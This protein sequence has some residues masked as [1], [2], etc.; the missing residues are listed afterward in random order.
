MQV[1]GSFNSFCY[2]F[3]VVCWPM[4]VFVASSL[5]LSGWFLLTTHINTQITSET[6]LQ[7]KRSGKRSRCFIS[8]GMPAMSWTLLE[9][10]TDVTHESRN[11][12]SASVKDNKKTYMSI[13]IYIIPMPSANTR[14]HAWYGGRYC[15]NLT[16]H[17][18]TYVSY[19]RSLNWFPY[20]LEWRAST[21][22]L[23]RALASC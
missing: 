15:C 2:K 13:Y 3:I 19:S 20:N 8:G 17:S 1:R 23:E 9:F 7:N 11:H 12:F 4:H 14:H 22:D 10:L 5:F 21:L 16:E 18:T 6:P